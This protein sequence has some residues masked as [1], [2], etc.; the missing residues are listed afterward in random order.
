MKKKNKREELIK[1]LSLGILVLAIVLYTSKSFDKEESYDLYFEY[2]NVK[3][4][5]EVKVTNKTEKQS[6][7]L[8]SLL[9]TNLSLEP[10][11]GNFEEVPITKLGSLEEVGTPQAIHAA[12][13]EAP[14]VI[15]HLP[16][17][18]GR[19]TQNPH[20]GHAAYDITSPRGSSETIFPVANGVISRIYTD[21]AGAL[22]V[23]VLHNVDGKKYTSQYA[24]LSRYASGL[25]EGKEVTINDALGQMGTTGNST[26][27]HLHIAVVDCALFDP[28]DPYCKDLN[29]FFRYANQKAREGSWGLGSLILVPESWNSR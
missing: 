21:A 27:I 9:I 7:S 28:N 14:R 26:G 20:F 18:M 17:E 6:H 23:T 15:W 10:I 5:A 24:H 16:T 29:G 11:T 1:I 25:Y 3:D 19:V 22:V 4:M 13:A 8:I 12:P 2:V